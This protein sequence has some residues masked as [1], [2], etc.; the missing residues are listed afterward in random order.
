MPHK[1]RGEEDQHLVCGA[2]VMASFHWH[3]HS[4]V[5]WRFKS[6]GDAAA[7]AAG[8]PVLCEKARQAA[9]VRTPHKLLT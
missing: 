8:K 9:K 4:T 7:M 2:G 5:S 1:S 3:R 6:G